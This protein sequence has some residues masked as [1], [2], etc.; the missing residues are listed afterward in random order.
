MNNLKEMNQELK[1][2]LPQTF[3][4]TWQEYKIRVEEYTVSN[5]LKVKQRYYVDMPHKLVKVDYRVKQ[6]NIENV[7][8]IK[9]EDMEIN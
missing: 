1:N 6:I 7:S 8:N 3:I 2:L 9:R 5:M 4:Y